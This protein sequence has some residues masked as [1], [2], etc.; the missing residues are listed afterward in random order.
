MSEF[1]KAYD[2]DKDEAR[3]YTIDWSPKLR[4]G[5]TLSSVAWTVPSGIT[6]AGTSTSG[7]PVVNTNIRL[8]GGTVGQTYKIEA[9]TTDSASNTPSAHFTVTITN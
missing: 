6:N 4:S 3:T 1:L 7:T 8:S 2:K 5:W 9:Q